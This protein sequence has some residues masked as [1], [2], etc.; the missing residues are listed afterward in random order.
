MQNIGAVN[1]VSPLRRRPASRLS[2]PL[3]FYLR[4]LPRNSALVNGE[5]IGSRIENEITQSTGTIMKSKH[6]LSGGMMS[7]TSNLGGARL[8]TSRLAR[9]LAP[10]TPGSGLPAL[11][12]SPALFVRGKVPFYGLAIAVVLQFGCWPVPPRPTSTCSVG[13]R[14]ISLCR[15]ALTSSLPTALRAASPATPLRAWAAGAGAEPR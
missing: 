15:P 2:F 7:F 11:P 3:H 8:L 4:L 14:R 1:E 10:P 5:H 13:R 9:T 12:V 6:A